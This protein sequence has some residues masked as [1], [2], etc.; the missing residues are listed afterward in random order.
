MAALFSFDRMSHWRQLHYTV[1]L[2]IANRV[3]SPDLTTDAPSRCSRHACM[4]RFVGGTRLDMHVLLEDPEKKKIIN[5]QTGYA[6]QCITD[7]RVNLLMD[8]EA[9]LRRRK[10]EAD[11]ST[12]PQ[13]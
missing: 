6:K 7:T 12:A 5:K 9:L 10:Q 3:I 11:A 8:N 4:F 1:G 2:E 13:R